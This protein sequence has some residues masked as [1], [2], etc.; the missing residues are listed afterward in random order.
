[1]RLSRA[2]VWR[3]QGWHSRGAGKVVAIRIGEAYAPLYGGDRSAD[4][5]GGGHCGTRRRHQRPSHGLDD[6]HVQPASGVRGSRRSDWEALG[7]RWQS[8]PRRRYG[9]RRRRCNQRG[10]AAVKS[11]DGRGDGGCSGIWQCR[12]AYGP[13][14]PSNRG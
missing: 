11:E 10:H 14:R 9:S 7:D 2:A 13:D 6:G 1:M 5:P 8:R 3:G 4:R 12:D